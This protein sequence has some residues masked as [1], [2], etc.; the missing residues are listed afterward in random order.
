MS[1]ELATNPAIPSHKFMTAMQ[2]FKKPFQLTKS[3]RATTLVF[4][5][6]MMFLALPW[7]WIIPVFR[8]AHF[9]G[10]PLPY[11]YAIILLPI[12]LVALLVLVSRILE[13]IDRHTEEFEN[14]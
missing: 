6:F 4:S 11:F 7:M 3:L 10:Q 12:L 1:I 8:D 2:I 13:D 14:E 9:L 5:A